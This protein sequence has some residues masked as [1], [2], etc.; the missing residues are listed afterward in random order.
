MN[1]RLHPEKNLEAIKGSLTKFGQQ[2]PI[3]I[4]KKNI[5]VAGNG[6]LAAA[7][8]LGW[9]DINAVV[10]ELDDLN[11]AAFALADNRT[12]ELAEW[13]SDILKESLNLLLLNDFDFSAIGL[14]KD[15][16]S[17]QLESPHK[18]EESATQNGKLEAY[19]N[20]DIRMIQ[21]P[22]EIE[23]YDELVSMLKKVS[24]IFGVDNNSDC[25]YFMAKKFL[26]E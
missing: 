11:K 7:K 20:A 25:V 15:D 9:K 2:K 12:S 8:A 16:F 1:A 21:L 26:N 3:V 24:E 13:D 18:A 19:L 17:L 23:K 6:T 5:V 22:I 14:G 4:D 10:T